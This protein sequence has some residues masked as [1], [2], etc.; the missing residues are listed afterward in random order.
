MQLRLPNSSISVNRP[1]LTGPLLC[2]PAAE[3]LVSLARLAPRRHQAM[4][5]MANVAGN[6]TFLT[7]LLVGRPPPAPPTAQAVP[8]TVTAV[9]VRLALRPNLAMP[10]AAP[11]QELHLEQERS[12]PRWVALARRRPPFATTPAQGKPLPSP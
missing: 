7:G 5:D 4:P 12:Q 2:T 6:T 3:A 8:A 10:E 9:L 1:C 11:L